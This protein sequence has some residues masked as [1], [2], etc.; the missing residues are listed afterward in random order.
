MRILRLVW[1]FR[2]MD[3]Q[4]IA[5]HHLQHLNEYLNREGIEVRDSG[6][7]EHSEMYASAYLICEEAMALKLREPLKP[8]AAYLEEN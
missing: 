3:A 8:H 5:A 1:E 6:V 4:Q 7:Q 2:G